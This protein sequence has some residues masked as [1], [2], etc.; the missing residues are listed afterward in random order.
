MKRFLILLLPLMMLASCSKSPK[1]YVI[2]VS[3]CSNDSW[4]MK[5]NEEL[6]RE[7]YFYDN[8]EVRFSSA[9]DNNAR[10]IAQI[11]RFV[12]EGVD[13]IIVSPNEAQSITPVVEKAYGKGI[14]VILVDRKTASK[15]YT[16]FIGADN[17]AIGRTVGEYVAARLGG[18]GNVVEIQG[19][20]G[21]SPATER[22][23]GFAE[24]M[25]R[26]PG[27]KIIS[28]DHY[29][30][31]LQPPARLAMASILAKEP[32]H[33]D[34]VFG[35]NDRIAMGAYQSM[36]THRSTQGTIFVGIDALPSPGG[37]I[38]AVQKG[39][40]S[41]TF[42][43][44]TCGDRVMKLAMDIVQHRSYC[45]DN[46]LYTA[47]V[48]ATNVRVITLQTSEI[49]KQDSKLE[50]LHG[51][52]DRYFT[53]YSTQKIFLVLFIIIIGLL[54]FFLVFI[55]R[56]FLT[57]KMLSQL[58]QQQ[59]D[60]IEKQKN[61]LLENNTTLQR[62]S[63]EVKQATQAKL[64]FFTN[65]SHEFRTPLTLIADPIDQ[66]LADKDT[67]PSQS[68]LLNL[69]KKNVATLLRLVNEILDFRKIENGKMRV[70]LSR[71][72]LP[73]RIREWM[74]EFQVA[75]RKKH[76]R[77]SFEM[78]GEPDFEVTGDLEKMERIFFNLVGNSFKFT[79]TG[80]AITVTL[81]KT[82]KEGTAYFLL[83]IADTG[84]GIREAELPFV[85]DRF[86]KSNTNVGGTGIGLALVRAFAELQGGQVSVNSEYG[87]GATFCIEIPV[88]QQN[89]EGTNGEGR[90]TVE[91][92]ASE[93]GKVAGDADFRLGIATEASSP[94]Q[95]RADEA[96]EEENMESWRP[97]VLIVDDNGDIRYYMRTLLSEAYNL[98][99]AVDGSDGLAK[100]RKHIPD[101]IVSDV[102]MPVMD[103][104]ELC[105]RLKSEMETSHI[106]I[107][108]L[109][110]R[111]LDEQKIEGFNCGADAYMP[112][113]FNGALLLARI[114]NLLRNR[115][116]LKSVFGD[117]ADIETEQVS[118][119]DKDFITR[120]RDAVQNGMAD[121]ELSVET[122]G[123]QLG[124]SRV[125]MYRK[126]KALTTYSPVELIR[127]A[128]LKKA[129][130]LIETT[131]MTIAEIA[132]A[133]G[134]ASPSYFAKCFK[135]CYGRSANEV[136]E[137]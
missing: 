54:M 99:E 86:Y 108:M 60:K 70:N 102:M 66:L 73:E 131:D 23:A 38:E 80:G 121:S 100:A 87:K 127:T 43:Y 24:A 81:S 92:P 89:A 48:D 84:I 110:A 56:A 12:D 97:T 50:T 62:L 33:I 17:K 4:R 46:T 137:R 106:P 103:G 136:R 116:I 68:R 40:L 83:S 26:F 58:L 96:T 41:A 25:K 123:A 77:L 3:Q 67:T 7:T 75:A 1:R 128:R 30:D 82:A 78:H 55:Y 51:K 69:M 134:F 28:S 98:I 120:F 117:K 88:E 32:R 91:T 29:A 5:L 113:P 112:K 122:L 31:W 19:R 34:C 64:V 109:T 21:S 135:E 105:R 111:S 65:I 119:I 52:V 37:G 2:G 6:R 35:Q 63:D 10:Q 59:N 130:R 39:I 27:I 13:L 42:I 36:K 125:Q 115:S 76:I 72:D 20:R 90:P 61:E 107:I 126:I 47:L 15:K 133:V 49:G 124:L 104:L 44:P 94:Q 132:Y 79:P 114:E 74:D 18:K 93:T 129:Y 14:P 16:A 101:I 22:H 118:D 45:R 53:Q 57:K 9:D 11:N 95:N 71:F 85:F 8:V